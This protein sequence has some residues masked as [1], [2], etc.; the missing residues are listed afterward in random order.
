MKAQ[1]KKILLRVGWVVF[2][3]GMALFWIWLV[4]SQ[5]SEQVGDVSGF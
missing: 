1:T 5:V 3:L 4:M 2:T